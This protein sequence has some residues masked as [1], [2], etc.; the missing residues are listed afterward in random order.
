MDIYRA[1]AE[2]Q[3]LGTKNVM[4]TLKIKEYAQGI[5]KANMMQT[6][7][8]EYLQNPNMETLSRVAS[9]DPL[10]A[11]RL[12]ETQQNMIKQ[13][14]LGVK[15]FTNTW[16]GS[17]PSQKK[18]LYEKFL[19]SPE[20]FNLENT[21]DFP[22][23]YSP[24]TEK[25]INN[26]FD[27]EEARARGYLGEELTEYG[28]TPEGYA[29]DKR[30]GRL[31]ELPGYRKR[32]E[33]REKIKDVH[34]R[35]RWVDTGELVFPHVKDKPGI[36]EKPPSGYQWTASGRLEPIPGGPATKLSATEAKT[37]GV[38][39]TGLE[40][41]K[42]FSNLLEQIG[43]KVTPGV[44]TADVPLVGGI[45]GMLSKPEEKQ[46]RAVRTNLADVIGR[47]RSGGAINTDEEK[48]FK[49]LLPGLA[50]DAKTTQFKLEQ[51]K[52]EISTVREGITR[53]RTSTYK[54]V[55]TMSDDEIFE[56]L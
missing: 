8:Q 42:N 48:R 28:K 5:Q 21:E 33:D 55:A 20:M 14:A 34:G 31:K 47:L 15:S 17:S 7:G 37:L 18:M 19:K 12:Q 40:N 35:Q 38:T 9:V 43:G 53:G 23:E 3:Q 16:K 10:H 2:G 36:G 39:T 56:E 52:R 54:D 44:L 26:L 27:Y 29:L 50:D 6:L 45:A 51:L 4:N 11:Q 1:Y 25:E 41:I 46:L 24:E 32:P 13:R 49:S 30:T 22:L